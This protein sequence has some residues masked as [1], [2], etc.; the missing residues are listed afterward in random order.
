M[1][2]PIRVFVA[3]DHLALRRGLAGALRLSCPVKT[4]ERERG[5]SNDDLTVRELEVLD[6]IA[7]GLTNA[8][9]GVE[10]K[11]SRATAKYH[12]SSILRKLGA[13]S[14]TEAAALAVQSHLAAGPA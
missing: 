4:Q 13:G 10:L 2:D 7:R 8:Q 9:I 5:Y 3:V 11:I 12:V 14:R 6:L 1:T